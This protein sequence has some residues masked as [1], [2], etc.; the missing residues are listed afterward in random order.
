[1]FV[2]VCGVT[3]EEDAL[4]AVAMGADAVGFVFAPSA[5]Q[6]APVQA[7]DIVRRLPYETLTIGVFRNEAP[8]R[9]VE[10]VNSLGL[11]GAQLHGLES[12]AEAAWVRQRV[13]FVVKAF[14]A[15]RDELARAGDYDVDALLIDAKRPGSG[16]VFDW[17][18][19]DLLPPD[20]PVILAGGL[21]PENVAEAIA[22]VA[23]WGV[24]V[25]TGVE[26]SPGR[27]DPVKVMRFVAAARQGPDGAAPGPVGRSLD[28]RVDLDGPELDGAW[29][30]DD[31]W[32]YDYDREDGGARRT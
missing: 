9:V 24:D 15:E 5:R 31:E 8:Q 25:S 1:V 14:A 11:R 17:D 26:A 6:I 27:K 4:L 13:P 7:R 23:P 19:V 2:K 18:L 16:E 20:R 3:N 28:G 29:P 10:V 12:P 32:P 30:S 21:T 22:T